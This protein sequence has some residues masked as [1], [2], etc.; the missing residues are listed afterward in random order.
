MQIGSG[1]TDFRDVAIGKVDRDQHDDLLTVDTVTGKLRIYAG[2]AGGVQFD[3]GVDPGAGAVWQ[4]RTD[5]VAV[6]FGPD[7]H[8][9]LLSKDP[10]GALLLSS[11]TAGSAVD[12][13]DPIRF[14]PRD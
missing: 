9:G 6:Q 8:D 13:M 11:T 12:W 10:S 3:P 7:E 5:L 1:W 2:N 4:N 14:G